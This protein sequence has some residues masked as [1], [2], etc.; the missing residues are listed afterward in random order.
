MYVNRN[1]ENFT[2]SYHNHDFLEIAYIAEG[3]GFHHLENSVQRV[4]KGQMFY[5]PLGI[6][7]V[8]RP[9]S[10]NGKPLIV[11]NCIFSVQLPKLIA[12]TTGSDTVAF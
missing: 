10:A 3:E 5:I 9:T 6:S 8:F 1:A 2:G 4:R 12:F 11:N 7:H